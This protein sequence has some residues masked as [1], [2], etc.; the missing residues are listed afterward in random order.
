M[1]RR[2]F[3]RDGLVIAS[4]EEM[5]AAG[6]SHPYSRR[7]VI[8][9]VDQLLDGKKIALEEKGDRRTRRANVYRVLLP[10]SDLRVVARAATPAGTGDNVSHPGTPLF[11]LKDLRE[12]RRRAPRPD[13]L[14]QNRREKCKAIR[15]VTWTMREH[16]LERPTGTCMSIFG[17]QVVQLRK[18]GVDLERLIAFAK[19]LAVARG[20]TALAFFA[21]RFREQA[22]VDPP[23][24]SS[25]EAQ[26]MLAS[27]GRSLLPDPGQAWLEERRAG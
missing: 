14:A 19:K 5:R 4:Y 25:A 8:R 10:L 6:G 1:Q 24:V 7:H 16:D 9:A 21:D 3:D 22:R 12:A 27:M 2:T 13:P 26:R 11:G 18:E 15:A 23:R 20:P 17:S